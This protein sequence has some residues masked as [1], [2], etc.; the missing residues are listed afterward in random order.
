VVK[1]YSKPPE[2]I[3]LSQDYLD[4]YKKQAQKLQNEELDYYMEHFTGLLKQIKWGESSR[5][6]F[7]SSVIQA[8]NYIVL[9]DRQLEKKARAWDARLDAIERKV[10][11]ASSAVRSEETREKDLDIISRGSMEEPVEEKPSGI[12]RDEDAAKEISAKPG[13]EKDSKVKPLKK[14]K[15]VSGEIRII[16][17]NLDRI[18]EALKKK[19]ISVYAM[20]IEAGLDRMEDGVLYFYLEENKKWHKDHLNKSDNSTIISSVI[21]EVT[22]KKYKVKFETG[23]AGAK[24]KKIE[25]QAQPQEEK[26]PAGVPASSNKKGE[27]G[28][29]KDQEIKK[30]SHKKDDPGSEKQE[31]V[32][33]RK[34]P[35]VEEDVMEYFEKKFDIKE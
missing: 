14:Q 9:D 21:G 6:F 32:D 25:G 11:G 8:L 2:L 26:K 34:N 35:G 7:K 19:K 33:K 31:K 5:T 16:E 30:V 23:K 13:K 18:L 29:G 10:N 22:G 27:S 24:K 12:I 1:N 17:D 3:D 4:K 28:P 20:F 15:A